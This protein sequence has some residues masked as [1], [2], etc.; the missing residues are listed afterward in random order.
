MAL[1][2]CLNSMGCPSTFA[3]KNAA[4]PLPPPGWMYS[5]SFAHERIKR[6]R[7]NKL[8]FAKIFFIRVFKRVKKNA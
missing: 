2:A 7:Q 1:V 6:S 3:L 8:V 4:P 5:M